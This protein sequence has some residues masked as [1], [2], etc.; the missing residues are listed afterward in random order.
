MI[1]AIDAKD[2]TIAAAREN[3]RTNVA[4]RITKVNSTTMKCPDLRERIVN[5]VGGLTDFRYIT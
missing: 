5:D 4:Q 3:G 2:A 1:A